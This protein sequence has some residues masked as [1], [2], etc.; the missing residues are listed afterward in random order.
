M[1]TLADKL[2]QEREYRALENTAK[3]T[4]EGQ[5][6]MA[7]RTDEFIHGPTLNPV[8]KSILDLRK[9]VW[10]SNA[11]CYIDPKDDE[12]YT[13]FR[14]AVF[15]GNESSVE[16]ARRQL[17]ELEAGKFC[18][19]GEF[20]R[21][22]QFNDPEFPASDHSLGPSSSATPILGWRCGPGLSDGNELFKDGADADDV[23]QGVFNDQ[24][25][26]AAVSM[27][28]GGG[29][30]EKDPHAVHEAIQN[31]F[32]GHYTSDG[33]LTWNTEVGA[34]C[35]RLH[36]HG[37]SIPLIVDD[38]FPML[39]TSLWTNE[40][41]GVAV[42]HAQECTE[43]WVTLI[44]KAFAK[45][46]GS[47]TELEKGY[48]HHALEE[49]TG[50]E[51]ECITLASA[52]RGVGKRTLW[53]KMMR[54]RRN[55][56]ILGAGTGSSEL[57]DREIVDMGI[58]F[59]ASYTIFD[60]RHID[61]HRLIK[62]R[63]PPGDHD[64]WKGDWSDKSDLW[65]KRLKHKLGWTDEDDNC[66]WMSF[67]DF[68]NVFRY[69]YCCKWYSKA[70]RSKSLP[71]IWKKSNETDETEKAKVK[72]K[73]D[74]SKD[75]NTP[76][77]NDIKTRVDTAGGLPH[78]HN[79]GCILEN[80]PHYSLNIH[81]PTDVRITV[82]QTDS[83]GVSVETVLPFAVFVVKNSHQKHPVRLQ[84]LDRDNVVAYT[85]EP[86]IERVQNIYTSL[87]P[88]LYVIL[89][90]AYMMGMEGNFTITVLS[91]YKSEFTPVWPPKWMMKK[92]LDDDKDDGDLQVAD[93][94]RAAIEGVGKRATKRFQAFFGI[95]TDES[96]D[97]DDKGKKKADIKTIEDKLPV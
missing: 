87:K 84:K 64:E 71:G 96:D 90:G 81:R 47:Y 75:V 57:V 82:S 50:C 43:L 30:G 65:T 77:S 24:W 26:L 53:E 95:S 69:L 10:L 13:L 59:G 55:G 19:L 3:A 40:N 60:V 54:F 4:R 23:Y 79:P 74:F 70:W 61:G 51:T 76:N 16:Y 68:C 34:Y 62:L 25:L 56:Y 67:D 97:E 15:V 83:R 73:K 93:A 94:A 88:G 48:V 22:Y 85:G 17:A 27:L 9:S 35:V 41:K 49:L 44:E 89:V 72:E 36:K 11:D 21:N 52:S 7:R 37:M 42:A 78:K 29:G 91:N 33:V 18:V 66:F 8:Q 92:S 1:L 46:Y 14:Q 12:L 58:Q 2:K 63:N 45:F 38:K 28:A 39:Q 6:E 32:V 5:V 86:K 20:G 80:N 31:L